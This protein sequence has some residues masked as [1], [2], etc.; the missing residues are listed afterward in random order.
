MPQKT[1]AKRIAAAK[2]IKNL[3]ERI[4]TLALLL[5]LPEKRKFV[6]FLE[7]L[8]QIPTQSRSSNSENGI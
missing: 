2:K 6:Q 3:D 7:K 8:C 1:L 4:M 5:P